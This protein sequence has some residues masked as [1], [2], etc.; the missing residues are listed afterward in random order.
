VKNS[1][2][3]LANKDVGFTAQLLQA[4][5]CFKIWAVNVYA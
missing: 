4:V 5:V 1:P 2:T 3:L